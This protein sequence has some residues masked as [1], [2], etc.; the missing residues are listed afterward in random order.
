MVQ[1]GDFSN[2]NEKVE[3]VFIVK[4]LKMKIPIIS[5]T[6]V[7]RA[8]QMQAA[9][10]VVLSTLSTVPNPHLEGKNTVFGQVI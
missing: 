6:K 8:W 10:Q 2:Q 1:G 3:K 7:Y 4:V 9:T 5:M